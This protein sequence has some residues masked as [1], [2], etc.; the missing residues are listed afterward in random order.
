MVLKELPIVQQLANDNIK[1][2]HNSRNGT[3]SS[4][5]SEEEPTT[6]S[7]QTDAS[8]QNSY[9]SSE[10]LSCIAQPNLIPY[11]GASGSSM[12]HHHMLL[13]ARNQHDTGDEDSEIRRRSWPSPVSLPYDTYDGSCRLPL[14][15]IPRV[16][17]EGRLAHPAIKYDI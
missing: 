14:R 3:I 17:S 5:A 12:Q 11:N 13:L 6:V 16:S 10:E 9:T 15:V 1:S 8:S 7:L 2:M 4:N